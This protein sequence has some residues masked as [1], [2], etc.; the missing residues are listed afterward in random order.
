MKPQLLT[1]HKGSTLKDP[2]MVWVD[3]KKLATLG[4]PAPIKKLLGY[5]MIV[6]K[7]GSI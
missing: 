1:L 6:K 5:D 7:M 2:T 3:N 4:L